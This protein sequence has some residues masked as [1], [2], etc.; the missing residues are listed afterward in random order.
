[1]PFL[2]LNT[3]HPS[4]SHCSDHYNQPFVIF[5]LGEYK[6]GW[7]KSLNYLFTSN[8]EKWG[9]GAPWFVFSGETFHLTFCKGLAHLQSTSM[10]DRFR[11]GKQF[12]R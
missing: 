5:K 8:M 7:E 10:N 4:L 9:P 12:F 1:M 3:V 11:E 2:K 6:K